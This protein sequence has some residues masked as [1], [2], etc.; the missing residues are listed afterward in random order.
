[1]NPKYPNLELIEYKFLQLLNQ[2]EEWKEKVIELRKENKY[3]RPEF[4]VIVFPQV[5]GSTNTAF[6][7]CEDGTPSVGG[8]AMTKA[9]T[10]VIEETLT[11]TYGIFI[12]EK[13]CYKV[14]DASDAFFSD[15]SDRNMASLSEAKEK[16]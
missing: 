4:E 3:A 13:A 11:K 7:V 14:T 15:L 5:W 9:Y 1:M 8:C 2:S 12:G 16:Y 10:T 6:D